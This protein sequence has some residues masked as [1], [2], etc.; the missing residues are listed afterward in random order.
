MLFNNSKIIISLLAL[1]YYQT[2]NTQERIKLYA[3][4]TQSH[5]VLKD[6]WFLPS[7]QDDYETIIEYFDQEC[8]SATFMQQ[9]WTKTT[10]HKVETWVQ[11]A[12]DNLG[13]IFICSDVDIQFFGSTEN[14][15]IK[16]LV[17]NDIVLQY[18]NL[19][20]ECCT[21]FFACQG[22]KKIIE[23]FENMLTLMKS[24]S[25]ISDQK[26]MN[27]FLRKHNTLNITWNYLPMIFFGGGAHTGKNWYPG[28]TLEIPKDILM[29]HANWSLGIDNKIAQLNYVHSVVLDQR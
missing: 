9:G 2:S 29:H 22:S 13:K 7:F 8:S 17:G 21:G 12:K 1:L 25:K 28:D 16:S 10:I 24:N 27:H 20:R 14:E 19:G 15:I 18:D 11:A 3:I 26:A 6:E 23:L 5:A 4:Y